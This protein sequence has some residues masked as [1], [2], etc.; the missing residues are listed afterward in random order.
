MKIRSIAVL[1]ASCAA[2]AAC[3]GLRQA[4]TAHVDVAA[5]AESQ[6]LSVTRLSDMLGNSTIQIPV[7]RETAM[8]LTDLWVNYQLLGVAAARGDTVVE[9]KLIDD[10]AMGI[11]ANAR[12]RDFMASVGKTTKPD[13]ATEST[14]T[15]AT[16]GLFVARH[17]L[18][19]V[20][21]G[22]TQQQ[23]DSV[24]RAAENVRTQANPANFGALAKRYSKD[25]GSAQQNGS[26][27]PFKRDE[28]VKPFGDAVA[29]LRPGQISPVVETQY[30]YH[31]IYRP[32]YA[33]AKTQYDPA[34]AQSS[35][36]RSE[37]LYVA[38][39]DQ[40]AN[41]D[42]KSNAGAVAKEAAKDL[43]AHRED[44]DV[45]ASF[46]GG[47][48]TVARFTRWVESFPPQMRIAQQMAAAP[49]SLVKQ[50]VKSIA[51]NEVLLLKAD[52]AGIKVPADQQQ[53][54][55]ADFKNLINSLWQQLGVEPRSL[56]DS[57]RSVPERER[58]AAAR[59]ESYLDRIMGGTAQPISIPLPVQSVLRSKY[60]AK[61]YPAGVDRAVERARKLRATA[62]STRAAQ[63]PR[64]QVPLPMPPADTARR[65]T[66]ARGKRP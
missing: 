27:G 30:G 58:L 65:D 29:A 16:G 40:E 50:F 56:A 49:D 52:S 18:I 1:V 60:D 37:S 25:P 6:E 19:P 22:A 61:V 46:K 32:T 64:S 55:Y 39:V 43:G 8:I 54:L 35:A 15:Q 14:Y 3:D 7:N 23:K 57:A 20:Q 45:L 24:R 9:P 47:Q 42:V 5:R 13:S 63:Q 51:R 17:I 31:I 66:S 4:F 26:L 41:I 53:Q 21:G 33:E 11:T 10:A 28:M 12:L 2:L 62:D 48:L 44:K 36:Q 59:I 34:Y 38:K